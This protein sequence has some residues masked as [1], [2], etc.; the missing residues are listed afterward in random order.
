MKKKLFL[1]ALAATAIISMLLTLFRSFLPN[2]FTALAAFPLEQIAVGLRFLSLS[3][4]A[5]NIIAIALYVLIS[6]IPLVFL[7]RKKHHPEDWFLVLLSLHLFFALY[8]MINPGLIVK[9]MTLS[10][11]TEFEKALLGLMFYSFLLGYLIIRM[12]RSFFTA[13]RPGLIRYLRILLGAVCFVLVYLIF[14]SGLADLIDTIGVL[15]KTNRGNELLLGTSYVF[16]VLQYLLGVLPYALDLVII[17]A[18]QQL[19][20]AE[21]Y[22]EDAILAVDQL[23]RLCGISLVLMVVSHAVYLVLQVIFLQNI[24]YSSVSMSIPIYSLLFVLV[25]LLAAQYIRENKQ[26][27]EDNNLFI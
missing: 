8:C 16:L 13:N 9:K 2:L 7:L 27:Q 12:V 22:S 3:G 18:T 6:L 4:A 19:L 24:Y 21:K 1:S 10:L 15:Q 17:F 25:V 14:G 5:G 20:Q 11:G 23:A 26:L